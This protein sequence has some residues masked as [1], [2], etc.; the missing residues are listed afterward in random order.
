MPWPRPLGRAQPRGRAGDSQRVDRGQGARGELLAV[1]PVAERTRQQIFSDGSALSPEAAE[2][3]RG[4]LA[5][6]LEAMAAAGA[7]DP[8]RQAIEA[9]LEKK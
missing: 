9:E 3:L 1:T 6:Q 5:R 2:T 8:H 7:A 4:C